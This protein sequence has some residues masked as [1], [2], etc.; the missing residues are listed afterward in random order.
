MG[1]TVP[2]AG[3]GCNGDIA[4]N[5]GGR[6]FLSMNPVSRRGLLTEER[7]GLKICSVSLVHPALSRV[8]ESR[9]TM[10]NGQFW[11]VTVLCQMLLLAGCSQTPV[12]R[13]DHYLG[14]SALGTAAGTPVLSDRAGPFD[15][16]LLVIN[17]CSAPDSAPA[18]SDK[19]RA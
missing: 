9:S 1:A 18:L 14:I 13:M 17:D 19:A 4:I 16:G 6:K 10:V 3:I 7:A 2:D 11:I 5:V 15:A 8:S 12:A